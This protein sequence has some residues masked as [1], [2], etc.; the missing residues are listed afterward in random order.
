MRIGVDLLG[1]ESL[2]EE[3]FKAVLQAAGQ[4]GDSDTLVV[5]VTPVVMESLLPSALPVRDRGSSAGKIDFHPVEEFIAMDDEPLSSVRLKRNSSLVV[6]VQQLSD[7]KIDAFVTA[8]NT[9]ALIASS[10]ILLPKLSGIERPP[11]LA[12]CPLKTDLPSCLMLGG[13]FPTKRRIL[14]SMRR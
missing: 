2:P 12:G 9:G 3:L 4:V 13:S 5:F 10:S 11:L 6:G 8:G 7:G 14:L 1:S